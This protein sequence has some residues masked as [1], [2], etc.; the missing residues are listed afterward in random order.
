M[1]ENEEQPATLAALRGRLGRG[2]GKGAADGGARPAGDAA[3]QVR[4]REQ[5]GLLFGEERAASSLASGRVLRTDAAA[6]PGTVQPPAQPLERL[7]RADAASP[8]SEPRRT[9]ARS[10]SAGEH[11]A[12]EPRARRREPE[13]VHIR[14][15]AR[16]PYIWTVR[17]IVADVRERV[18]GAHREV[19]IEGEIST[20]RPASSGHL[21]LSLK[22]S[23]AQL[24]VVVFR[25]QAQLLRFRPATGMTVLVRG[26]LSI[27]EGRGELQLIAE[28]LEPRGTGALLLAFERLKERLAAEGLFDAARKRALPAFPKTVGIVTSTAGA[29]LHDVITVVRRRHARLNLLV[30]PARVQGPGC[31]AS[32][33]AG[34]AWFNRHPGTVDVILLARGGG[35][36]EDLCGFNEEAL[37]RAIAASQLPV[38]SAIGHETDFSIADF[39][40][41]LRA[42]TPSAAAELITASQFRIEERLELL[43]R[44]LRR[45]GRLRLLEARQRFARLAAEQTMRRVQAAVNRRMQ[46]LDEMERRLESAVAA[47]A[48][49]RRGRL[50]QMER[51]LERQQIGARLARDTERVSRLEQ[52][53]RH[54]GPAIAARRRSAVD[55]ATGRLTALSPLAVLARGYALVY[56]AHEA[57][58]AD[59]SATTTEL[60]RGNEGTQHGEEKAISG[61]LRLV[62]SSGEVAPGQRVIA[63]FAQ[64]SVAAEVTEIDPR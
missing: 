7:S 5:M 15:V 48:R 9:P 63:R 50:E 12:P 6:E 29:V 19:L 20:C 40:A 38:V 36:P 17:G 52:R 54:A 4:A 64:G 25:K 31:A 35:S 30:Y 42:P 33:A 51:R 3:E 2:R 28:S 49:G 10:P 53:L 14:P 44:G 21:Y 22:D 59:V 56:A 58:A 47:R 26:R 1:A 60:R 18:E 11:T 32:V 8:L 62:R 13:Q 43:E 41:D 39:V 34:V 23:E 45:A 27:Y 46:R 55:R 61:A 57:G 16:E 24:S 37:A